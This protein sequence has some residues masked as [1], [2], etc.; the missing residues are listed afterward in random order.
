MWLKVCKNPFPWPECNF[1][2]GFYLFLGFYSFNM[3]T[4]YLTTSTC[5]NM[6][7]NMYYKYYTMKRMLH[8]KDKIK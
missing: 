8:C 5:I 4:K 2:L 6:Y 1:F 3:Y 7:Y